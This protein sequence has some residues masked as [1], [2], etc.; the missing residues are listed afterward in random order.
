MQIKVHPV[1][2]PIQ[3]PFPAWLFQPRPPHE[4]SPGI[5]SSS[6]RGVQGPSAPSSPFN[7]SARWR[8]E[9]RRG[10]W[11]AGRTS[12]PTPRSPPVG[13]AWAGLLAS[14]LAERPLQR[15]LRS[16]LHVATGG[17]LGFLCGCLY[18]R[19]VRGARV[20]TFPEE[21]GRT[22]ERDGWKRCP[23]GDRR[24]K[25]ER[26]SVSDSFR[27]LGTLSSRHGLHCL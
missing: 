14:L 7:G 2:R 27:V 21:E 19:E 25:Q 5:T 10:T 9:R 11:L 1:L 6:K 15:C 17:G 13:L 8:R 4:Q 12:S 23:A 20:S 24:W 18:G 26:E 22:R 16:N 3:L